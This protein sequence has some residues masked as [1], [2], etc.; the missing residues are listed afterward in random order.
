MVSSQGPRGLAK[1]GLLTPSRAYVPNDGRG[2]L[3]LGAYKWS[4]NVTLSRDNNITAEKS[5]KRSSKKRRVIFYA[6]EEYQN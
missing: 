6:R 5:T 2:D 4:L 1:L 3:D